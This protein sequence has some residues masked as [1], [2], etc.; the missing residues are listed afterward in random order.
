[1]DFAG[2]QQTCFSDWG[3]TVV[4]FF[5]NAKFSK[6]DEVVHVFLDGLMVGHYNFA[7]G[8]GQLVDGY[9]VQPPESVGRF[10]SFEPIDIDTFIEQ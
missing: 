2:A 4:E 1:M 9:K 7:T 5:P 6:Y 10:A 8:T 3:R